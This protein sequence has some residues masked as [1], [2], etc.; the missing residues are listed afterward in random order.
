MSESTSSLTTV[1]V[2]IGL[3]N[4]GDKYYKN[5][6]SIGFRVIDYFASQMNASWQ[7]KEVMEY[8]E[9]VVRC[10]KN[11]ESFVKNISLVKPLS[12]MNNS[13]KVIPSLI[14]KGI[15]ST[16]ILVIH[17]E[18][19]KPF[20]NVS[21]RFNGSARGH[22]GLRSL[23]SIMG[24]DFWHL[25]F[26]IGRPENRDLVPEYVLSNFSSKEESLIEEYICKAVSSIITGLC[27]DVE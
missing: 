16:E 5:R 7:S 14:K 27:N 2:I 11:G 19:E 8:S 3:G 15:K 25:R 18:L 21:I 20:G 22:N 26:G 24:K 10:E 6:H 12:Y 17:D 13:G 1:K 23:I 9:A 4:P